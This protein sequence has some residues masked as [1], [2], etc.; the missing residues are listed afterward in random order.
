MADRVAGRVR[1]DHKN[2]LK[3]LGRVDA[4]RKRADF[5][6]F[7]RPSVHFSGNVCGG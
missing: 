3:K 4:D 1:G 2:A 5:R 7:L 6:A